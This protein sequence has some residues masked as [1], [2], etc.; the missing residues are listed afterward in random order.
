M[1]QHH[2]LPKV[3]AQLKSS[4][5]VVRLHLWLANYLDKIRNYFAGGLPLGKKGFSRIILFCQKL[6]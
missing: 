6:P 5:F 3:L 1:T 4:I 2:P